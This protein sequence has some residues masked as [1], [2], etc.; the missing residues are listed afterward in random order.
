MSVNLR[1]TKKATVTCETFEFLTIE[2]FFNI[3]I[4][5]IGFHQESPGA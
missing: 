4:P 2:F 1:D 5:G 3:T